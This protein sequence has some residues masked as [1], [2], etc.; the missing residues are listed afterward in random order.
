MI[1]RL[2]A[3]LSLGP[4]TLVYCCLGPVLADRPAMPE[5]S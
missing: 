5:G 3:R 1:A 4:I 2:L